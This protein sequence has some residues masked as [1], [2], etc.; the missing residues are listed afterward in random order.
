MSN[1][2]NCCKEHSGIDSRV[3]ILEKEF[4]DIKKD[5]KEIKDKLLTRPPLWST[6]IISLAMLM[7]G[8]LIKK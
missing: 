6:T 8:Y 1:V 3:G 4:A 5:I 7:I 2:E